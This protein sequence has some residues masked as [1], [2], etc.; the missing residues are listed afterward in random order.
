[1]PNGSGLAT[2]KRTDMSRVG[3][4]NVIVP[5]DNR[6]GAKIARVINMYDQRDVLTGERQARKINWSRIS[7]QRGGGTIL[8]GDFNARSRRYDPRCNEHRD[9]TFWEE[10]TDEQGLKIGNHNQPTHHQTGKGKLGDMTIHLTVSIRPMIRWT[11]LDGWHT[12]RSDHEV[13]E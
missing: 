9:R 6:S 3:N 8:G 12:T 11:I 4:D 7:R 1:V 5:D 10:I 2:D 13:I